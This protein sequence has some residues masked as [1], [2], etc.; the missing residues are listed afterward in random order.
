MTRRRF[1]H[2][3]VEVSLATGWRVPRFQLWLRLRELGADPE[4]IS[5]EEIVAFCGGPLRR[6]LAERGV[7][8]GP[9]AQRRLLRSVR[10]YDPTRR[11]PEE[12]LI[13]PA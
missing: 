6:F 2:L 10:R 1:D 9:R 12:H 8:L 13:D 5:G 3:V 7:A 11:E 4:T